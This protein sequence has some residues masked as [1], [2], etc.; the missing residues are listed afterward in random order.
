MARKTCCSANSIENGIS[1]E[2]EMKAM[3]AASAMKR[4]SAMTA[5]KT[6]EGGVKWRHRKA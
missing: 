2:N 5:T 3:A 6:L 1:G 4:M